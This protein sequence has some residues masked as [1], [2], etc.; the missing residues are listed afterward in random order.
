MESLVW[1]SSG[2]GI[3]PSP[4][5]PQAI[6]LLE[7]GIEG[8]QGRPMLQATGCD[9][10]VIGRNRPSRN[11]CSSS[12]LRASRSP[13]AKPASSLP[14]TVTPSSNRS[15]RRIT[16]PQPWSP[17]LNPTWV[18]V[19]RAMGRMAQAQSSGSTCPIGAMAAMKASASCSLQVPAN[20]S[21]SPG[22]GLPPRSPSSGVAARAGSC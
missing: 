17:R 18:L 13:Q 22:W 1:G 5:H 16:S 15:A 20:A 11:C 4:D 9:P 14:I 2:K 12:L 3:R 8:E 19:P 6:H 7:V 21:S 10:E